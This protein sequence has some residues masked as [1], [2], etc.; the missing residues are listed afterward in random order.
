MPDRPLPAGADGRRPHESDGVNG[1]ARDR[2]RLEVPFLKLTVGLVAMQM[3][4]RVEFA[5]RVM[6]TMLVNEIRLAQ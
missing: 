2:D 1:D 4:M 3:G 6:V 5:R